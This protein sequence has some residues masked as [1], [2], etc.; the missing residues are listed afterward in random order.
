MIFHLCCHIIRLEKTA[1]L[2]HHSE[3]I[4][5]EIGDISSLLSHHSIRKNCMSPSPFWSYR[6]WLSIIGWSIDL[7]DQ[8][9]DDISSLL[10]HHSIRKNRMSPSRLILKL[11]ILIIDD[12]LI[13]RSDRSKHL[14]YFVRLI[15]L[16]DYKRPHVSTCYR[17]LDMTTV[18]NTQTKHT[19]TLN[20]L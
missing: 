12:W 16:I 14:W 3:V 4:D 8:P 1:C 11:S 6:F 17:S 9:I 20:T 19:N 5:F 10:S 2:H 15:I 13:D 7:I 18:T